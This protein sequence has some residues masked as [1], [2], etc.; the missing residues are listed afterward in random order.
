MLSPIY[1]YTAASA[2][3]S[4]ALFVEIEYID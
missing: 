4:R 1:G 3:T 2:V